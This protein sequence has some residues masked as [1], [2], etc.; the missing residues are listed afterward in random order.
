[1]YYLYTM[2]YILLHPRLFKIICVYTPVPAGMEAPAYRYVSLAVAPFVR[3]ENKACFPFPQRNFYS[4]FT[5]NYYQSKEELNLFPQETNRLT[6]V[7]RVFHGG[8]NGVSQ[9]RDD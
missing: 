6:I 3:K 8:E 5:N 2:Q 7:G 9:G 1:M 4:P